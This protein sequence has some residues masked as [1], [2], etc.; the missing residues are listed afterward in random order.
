MMTASPRARIESKDA[1]DEIVRVVIA[2]N[3]AI[4]CLRLY[5]EAHP[6]GKKY[7]AKI[8]AELS[9]VLREREEMTLLLMEDEIISENKPL[10]TNS[11]QMAQLI[12]D[13]RS[14][15][16]E[17]LTFLKGIQPAELTD[18]IRDIATNPNGVM[19]SRTHIRLGRLGLKTQGPSVDAPETDETGPVGEI[20]ERHH[21]DIQNFV[22]HIARRRQID[23]RGVDDI[24]KG[25]IVGLACCAN[26]IQLLLKMR[27]ADEYTY[28][29]MVNVCIL[30][31]SQAESLGFTG[32]HLYR[33]GIASILHDAGK[34]FIPADILNK[35]GKLSDSERSIIE[36]HSAKG[37]SFI[38]RQSGVP[39]LAAVG[40]LEHHIR[41]DG[42]GYP[43]VSAAH[44][45]NIV[46]QMIAISDV[47]DAMRSRR[48]YKEAKPVAEI[49]RILKQEKG[50][51]FNPQLVANFLK[52]IGGS[53]TAGH[54]PDPS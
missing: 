40:A 50:K 26:P 36:T 17:S 11:Q 44:K 9:G 37:A 12:K 43:N 16:L 39:K 30:T 4:T 18:F 25:F 2:L 29:H 20:S 52:L 33:I 51:S 53:R 24:I 27:S 45:P 14:R 34:L 3:S 13:C 22:H 38:L 32:D 35:P 28:T 42:G 46:S 6:L 41:Y 1:G 8:H 5:S 47:F 54:R 49:V 10:K 15:G 21:G 19:V 23:I 48:P 7:L 31:M